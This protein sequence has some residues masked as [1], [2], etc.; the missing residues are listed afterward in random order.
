M[1][2]YIAVETSRGER[3]VYTADVEQIRDFRAFRKEFEKSFAAKFH[4]VPVR[5]CFCD[6]LPAARNAL[7]E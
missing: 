6:N 3:F 1:R 5:F 4:T 7:W 2:R